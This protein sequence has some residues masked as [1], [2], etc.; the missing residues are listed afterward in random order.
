M[1]RVGRKPIDIVKGVTIKVNGDEVAVNGPKGDLKINT[2]PEVKVT[3][4]EENNQVV[5]ERTS[6]TRLARAMHG[7]TRS[8]I[9]NMIVGVTEGYQ[10]DLQIVGVGWGAN[11]VG[12]K[13]E[14]NLGYA[15]T[16]VVEVPSNVNCE[17]KGQSI[18]ISGVDKQA[19]GQLAAKIRQHRKPEPYNG[20]G[21]MF[22]G[23]R[24]LRKQG[25]AFGS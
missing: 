3:L 22:V 17:V 4:D 21:V 8:L 19:V 16:R 6:E 25:K 5:V 23:E 13:V 18:K 9:Q 1:S 12:N 7:T 11:L 10:K 14:L 15:D 24:V 20:K 2:R